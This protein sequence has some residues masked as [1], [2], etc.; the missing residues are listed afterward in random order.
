M[1]DFIKIDIVNPTIIQRIRD[2]SLLTFDREIE[3]ANQ[4]TGLLFYAKCYT[5]NKLNFTIYVD[6]SGN[7]YKLFISGSLHYYFNGGTHNANDFTYNNFLEV[8]IDLIQK[9]EINPYECKIRSLEFGINIIPLK[10][11][12]RLILQN[13]LFH[14]RKKFIEPINKPYKQSGNTQQNDFLLKIYDKAFQFPEFVTGEL[15]RFEVKY[16]RMRELR[17]MGIENLS[18]LLIKDNHFRL[19]DILV[20]RFSEVLM[21][22]FTIMLNKLSLLKQKKCSNYSNSNYWENIL[23][24]IKRGEINPKNFNY[25]TK[26]LKKLISENSDN[27]HQQLTEVIEGKMPELL[28]IPELELINSEIRIIKNNI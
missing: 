4:Q 24:G 26:S 25:H 16:C 10:Y 27:I 6:D 17:K 23:I 28:N 8:I 1:I 2:N 19:Y 18:D 11:S 9:F 21:Y 5:Y 15:L 7:P 20:Q 22:D 3:R 12:T 13:T 14:Q